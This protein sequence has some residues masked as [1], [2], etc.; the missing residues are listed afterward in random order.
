MSR[1]TKCVYKHVYDFNKGENEETRK[2]RTSPIK[3]NSK[4]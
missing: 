4:E 3:I 1:K 2:I